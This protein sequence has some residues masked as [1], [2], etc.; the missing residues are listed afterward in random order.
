M[1]SQYLFAAVFAIAG[2]ASCGGTG[3]AP[4]PTPVPTPTPT[5]TPTPV[6][7]V[8]LTIETDKAAYAPGA[9][10]R[11]KVA[12]ASA[13]PAGARIRMT[14]HHL[15]D[16]V[17]APVEAAFTAT[18]HDLNWVAPATDYKGY[19]VEIALL[20][21]KGATLGRETNAIDVSS[22][23][24][25]F[26]RYGYLSDFSP[27]L[28]GKAMVEQLKSYHIN[29]LQYYD[30]Q[31]KH[32]IPL[33]AGAAVWPD[34]ANRPTSAETIKGMIA[35]ARSMGMASM[36]Y[37]LIYGAAVDYAAD[38]VSPS[39]GLYDTKGGKQWMY[40]LPSNW[41]SPGLYF[42]NPANPNWQNWIISRELEV[43]AA[44][45]FD[46]WHADTVGDNGIKYDALG[47]PVDIKDTFKPFLNAAKAR[48]GSKLLVMN[49]VG[50]KGHEGV[51]ASNVD[52]AYVEVWPGDG[53]PDYRSL[54][55]VVDLTR[56]ES[57]GKS[58]IIPAYMNYDYAKTK[59]DQAPG[60]FNEPGVLL[61]E[62]TVLAAGGSRLEL[63]DGGHMLC[64]EYF[65]NKAL[66]MSAAL[67]SKIRYYYDFAVASENLLRDGQA[68][69]TNAVAIEGK[70]VS[71]TGAA[72]TVW[73]ITKSDARHEVVNLVN[74]LGIADTA[75]R[76]T[77]ATQKK[78][79]ALPAFKLKYYTGTTM[80]KAFAASPD[81]DGGRS[82]A[83]P[84]ETG[85][86]A[87][88]AFVAVTVPGLEYWNLIYFKKS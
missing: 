46:G 62:A 47:N 18:P 34:L 24:L 50:N 44:Y 52:A 26:P 48:L 41:T 22:S 60:Q 21:D 33:K 28:N 43:F 14:V 57:G 35:A 64:H 83:L 27:G 81:I 78:P 79:S 82:V 71:T 65:P 45:D 61:T 39:W 73:A 63:G 37:N 55:D 31:W 20:D 1:N 88:G 53:T 7:A 8:A 12:L 67:K 77:N 68:N 29:A 13:V 74:L 69:T 15:G 86:D 59:N 10:A 19:S 17:G 4:A 66:L 11:V 49:A 16:I 23:W 32:H 25:K 87:K 30:W 72:N 56:A 42:F 54:R 70:T 85:S 76:D 80:A 75:W 5:P 2:L 84:M 51:N 36:Q 6:P 3:G 38:G 40:S 9:T 58:V